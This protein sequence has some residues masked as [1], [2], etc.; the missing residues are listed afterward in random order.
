[1]TDLQ[2]IETAPKDGTVIHVET[3][4]GVTGK[5]MFSGKASWRGVPKPALIDPI[6]GECFSQAHVMTGWLLHG[7]PYTVPGK[8]VGWK[9]TLREG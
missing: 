1:M 7:R 4:G 9:H 2:P 3:V 8:I 6:S 5:P